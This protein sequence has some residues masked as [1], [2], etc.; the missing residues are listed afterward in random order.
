MEKKRLH[1]IDGVRGWAAFSVL[2]FHIL[3]EVFG[4]IKPALRSSLVYFI[5]NGHLAVTIFFILSGDALSTGYLKNRNLATIDALLVKRYFRLT[6]PI[7]LSCLTVY[8]LMKA[9]LTFNIE[10]GII[11]HREDWLVSVIQFQPNILELLYYAFYKV[12]DGHSSLISY[13]PFL[14]TMSVELIGSMLVFL[15][16]YVSCYNPQGLRS[17]KVSGDEE[18]LCRVQ[19][20]EV[21]IS[22]VL[23]RDCRV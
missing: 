11:I 22:A 13:N 10:A 21:I 14:W 16:L 5:F 18:P 9:G 2:L 7:F 23:W 3:F 1:V 8:I 6:M 17:V 19:K 12:Y 20:E 15:F 4:A